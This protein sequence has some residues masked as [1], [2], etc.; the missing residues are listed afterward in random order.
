MFTCG[1]IVLALGAAP[2][3]FTSAVERVPLVRTSAKPPTL[4]LE[5]LANRIVLGNVKPKGTLA[6]TLCPQVESRAEETTLRCTS[7]RLWAELSEDDHGLFLDLRLLRGV[8]WVGELAIPLRAWPIRAYGIPDE[9]PGRLDA[10]R[11]Q[12]ALARG[13]V[14]EAERYFK[15]ARSSPDANFAYLRLA[16]LAVQR[17][18][19][20]EALHLFA[21]VPPS[22]P[23]GRAARARLCDLTGAC[24]GEKESAAAG[25]TLGLDEPLKGELALIFWR[26]ELFMGREA[27][28]MAPFVRALQE[29]PALCR[30]TV[31]L[32]QLMLIAGLACSDENARAAALSGWLI[33]SV[34]RGP[35][36][37]ALTRAASR[38]AGELGA[39]SFA[40]AVLASSSALVPT[41]ELNTHLLRAVE[42]Y[43]EARDPVR[44]GAIFDYAENRLGVGATSKGGWGVVRAQLKG[45]RAEAK[46]TPALP[47][48]V[49]S[50]DALETNVG[51]ATELARAAAARS[52]AQEPA[53][54]E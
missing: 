53:P 24:L 54:H 20:E 33:Q 41:N 49:V 38:A 50:V 43:L 25:D 48:P 9:C 19:P 18:A 14:E 35:Y 51:L 39:P 47:A 6:G 17:G 3:G 16:E 45:K 26:R 37:L 31:P 46:L 11:G 32:C 7:R 27:T 40:A 29:N 52:R 21:F 12:C 8:P 23:I 44:A 42:L 5:P 15:K 34:R 2:T 4:V 36:E 1:L 30:D 13:D 28:V 22:G 10:T